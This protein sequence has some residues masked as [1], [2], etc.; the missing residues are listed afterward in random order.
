MESSAGGQVS[1]VVETAKQKTQE[2]TGE[3]VEKGRSAARKQV[4]ERS[5][6]V[7][8]QAQSLAGTL[9]ETAAQLRASGD[10]QKARHARVADQGADRLDRVGG[11]LSQADGEELLGKA[12]E[13]ARQ[14]PWLMAGAGLLVGIAAARF[15]KASSSDRYRQTAARSRAATQPWQA[16][17][18]P[19]TAPEPLLSPEQSFR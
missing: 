15:M 3:V 9:R 14:Q 8:M 16:A 12:E 18:L 2:Q 7:G 17:A 6:Q 1:D 13:L 4:D 11:Y 5:T 10:E 19:P